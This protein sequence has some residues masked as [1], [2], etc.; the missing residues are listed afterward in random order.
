MWPFLESGRTVKTFDTI[1]EL[2]SGGCGTVFLI[3]HKLDKRLYA[4]KKI[5]V[6]TAYDP[7]N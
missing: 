4:L 7:E 3:K 1:K 5:K 6:H 2:G